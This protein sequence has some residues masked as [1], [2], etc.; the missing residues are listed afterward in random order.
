MTLTSTKNTTNAYSAGAVGYGQYINL[1]NVHSDVNIRV[2]R[3]TGNL[4]YV[5]GI[6]GCGS[7][8]NITNCTNSGKIN[9]WRYNGGIVGSVSNSSTITGCVNNGAITSFSTCAAGIVASLGNGCSVSACYNTGNIVSAGNYGAGIVGN[10]NNAT[11]KNCFNTGAITCSFTNGSV[12]GTISNSSAVIANLYYLEGTAETGIGTVADET[13]QKAEAVSAETLA[14]AEFVSAM[15]ESL[16]EAAF[17]KG[18]DYPILAWQATETVT[19][20]DLDGDGIVNST[21]AAKLY[22]LINGGAEMTEDQCTAA[23]VNGDGDV[24]ST[25]AAIIYRVA[26][27]LLSGFPTGNN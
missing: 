3:T 24:N 16:E 4:Q 15:N 22:R 27:G 2:N 9:A 11:V 20:G 6:L 21:D 19:L 5:A 14:S 23:D 18:T 25:D 12:I 10:C 26:N 1:T 13:T 7:Y 17:V 8:A